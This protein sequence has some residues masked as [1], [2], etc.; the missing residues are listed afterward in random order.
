MLPPY[1]TLKVAEHLYARGTSDTSVNG[2]KA[3]QQGRF[4]QETARSIL[5]KKYHLTDEQA[6]QLIDKMRYFVKEWHHGSMV[7]SDN[8]KHVVRENYF[9]V[10]LDKFEPRTGK[11][12]YRKMLVD[13]GISKQ[14]SLGDNLGGF[15]PSTLIGI[16]HLKQLIS[17]ATVPMTRSGIER[18]V[19]GFV[20]NKALGDANPLKKTRSKKTMTPEELAEI[21]AHEK[22]MQEMYVRDMTTL[23]LLKKL[24]N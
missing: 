16:K 10:N 8:K 1:P 4:P 12:A 15:S 23:D 18:R 17:R 5:V 3:R 20:L 13:H 24:V 22:K 11:D 14:A 19:G 9:P 6:D 7:G 2:W 21:A